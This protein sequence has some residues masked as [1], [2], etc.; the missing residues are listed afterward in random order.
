[1]LRVNL[2]TAGLPA[3]RPFHFFLIAAALVIS[4]DSLLPEVVAE[5]TIQQI[6]NRLRVEING[7][8]ITEYYAKGYRKPVLYPIV[9]PHGVEMTRNYPMK[10]GIQG[11]AEDHPHHR[12]LWFAHGSVNGVDFWSERG[13]ILNDRIVATSNGEQ[14][15]IETANRWVD[16]NDQIVCTDRQHLTF[17]AIPG[18]RLIDWKMTV[19]AS[20]GKVLFGDTKEGMAGIRSHPNLRLKNA[21]DRGVTSANGQAINSEG[22]SGPEIWGK[23]A[24]WV[25]YWGKVDGHQI[26]FAIFDHPKNLRHPTWWHARTYGLVAANPFGIHDFENKPDGTGDF[27]LSPGE[28]VTFQYRFVFH[29][30]NTSEANISKL[31]EDY[32]QERN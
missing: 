19:T 18:G 17:T 7:T 3:R 21:P 2:L 6:E 25:D 26:G 30:G 10:T 15:T 29:Q 8:L 11:E 16:T 24:A 12:S 23:R 4:L 27:M 32:I 1:M 9:G 14:G 5:V 20:H 22:I 13:Q 31:Y 28:K